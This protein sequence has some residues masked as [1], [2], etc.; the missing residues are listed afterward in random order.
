MEIEGE[1]GKGRRTCSAG[2]GDEV[3]AMDEASA[4]G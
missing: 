4:E 2:G 3:A 1:K